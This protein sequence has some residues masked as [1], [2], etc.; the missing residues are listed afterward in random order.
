MAIKNL[1]VS[2][3]QKLVQSLE[4]KLSRAKASAEGP[5][6]SDQATIPEP[7]QAGHRPPQPAIDPTFAQ[8]VAQSIDR[9]TE[10]LTGPPVDRPVAFYL[11]KI[12]DQKIDEAVLY[13]Q[14]RHS[15]KIDRSAVVSALLA[16]PQLWSHESLDQLRN[17]VIRQLT[18]RL[19]S[20][21]TR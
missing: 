4:D 9:S 13:Y 3:D 11:P 18:Y 5:L 16:D 21:L 19:T 6:A 17:K 8:P 14:E 1:D 2:P 15:Q 12:I 7:H 20:R 10:P